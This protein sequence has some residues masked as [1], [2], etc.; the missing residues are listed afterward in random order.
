MAAAIVATPPAFSLNGRLLAVEGSQRFNATLRWQQS[1]ASRILIT[2]P[3][4]QALA[5]IEADARGA[6]LTAADG[7][8]Y[9]AAS[10]A[11][12]AR[13]GLGLSLPLDHLPWWLSGRAAPGLPSSSDSDGFSQAGWTVRFA[14]RDAAGRPLRIEAECSEG[15]GSARMG[16]QSAPMSV[17]L[18]IDQWLDP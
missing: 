15:C 8:R 18:I 5:S 3:L 17:L 9:N 2:T 1:D 6:R 7:R 13:R 4:G 10:L 16:S 12:L 14:S 11:D